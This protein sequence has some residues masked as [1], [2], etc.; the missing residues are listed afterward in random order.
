[1]PDLRETRLA[2]FTFPEKRTISEAGIVTASHIGAVE[3]T[4]AGW[5]L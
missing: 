1:M 3:S 2:R 4:T 5:T